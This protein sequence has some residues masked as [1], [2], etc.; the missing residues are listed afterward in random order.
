[1][2]YEA[3]HPSSLPLQ[4][5][6]LKRASLLT[7][8][9]ESVVAIAAA[10][11][12]QF[13]VRAAQTGNGLIWRQTTI[14]EANVSYLATN[15]WWATTSATAYAIALSH[16][17]THSRRSR[18]P[19]CSSSSGRIRTIWMSQGRPDKC[20]GRQ[21]PVRVPECLK[22]FLPFDRGSISDV[23]G[24][25][26]QPDRQYGADSLANLEFPIKVRPA[27]SLI[28]HADVKPWTGTSLPVSVVITPTTSRSNDGENSL[29]N[30]PNAL[31]IT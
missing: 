8:V 23:V 11:M 17:L 6:W 2:D 20:R 22:V 15:S 19:S 30:I 21:S 5:H 16:D 26:K 27:D 25:I 9:A 31:S 12:V 4:A 18:P 14:R 3:K 13:I 24:F 29:F 7:W 28:T 1:L 10:A